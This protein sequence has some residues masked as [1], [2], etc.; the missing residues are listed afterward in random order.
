MFS[1]QDV[2]SSL[3]SIDSFQDEQYVHSFQVEEM[4]ESEIKEEKNIAN[5]IQKISNKIN[6]FTTSFS[7]NE[8]GLIETMKKMSVLRD[9]INDILL[10]EDWLNLIDEIDCKKK[11]LEVNLETWEQNLIATKDWMKILLNNFTEKEFIDHS[12]LMFEDL[13]VLRFDLDL[14]NKVDR[15]DGLDNKANSFFYQTINLGDFVVVNKSQKDKER[16]TGSRLFKE[17]FSPLLD[18]VDEKIKYIE[19][20]GRVKNLINHCFLMIE[21]I[22]LSR[23]GCLNS[24]NRF[25]VNLTIDQKNKFKGQISRAQQRHAEVIQAAI[26]EMHEYLIKTLANAINFQELPYLVFQTLLIASRNRLGELKLAGGNAEQIDL[27]LESIEDL[28]KKLEDCKDFFRESRQIRAQFQKLNEEAAIEKKNMSIAQLNARKFTGEQIYR[29]P[30]KLMHQ[31]ASAHD[32]KKLGCVDLTT[33]EMRFFI[34]KRKVA[35]KNSYRMEI[36]CLLDPRSSSLAAVA[37]MQGDRPTQEDAHIFSLLDFMVGNK[38]YQI[39]LYGIFDGHGG[40]D[41]ASYLAENLPRVLQLN[42]QRALAQPCTPIEELAAIFNTLKTLYEELTQEY[43]KTS[44]LGGSTACI[45]LIYKKMLIAANLGDSRAFINVN[46]S[47]IAL[48]EDAAIGDKKRNRSV[49]KR[50]GFIVE[51][52]NT[53]RITDD[54]GHPTLN[55]THSACEKKVLSANT[56]PKIVTFPLHLLPPGR[57]QLVIACDG[58]FDAIS[59]ISAAKTLHDDMLEGYSIEQAAKNM[60]RRAYSKGSPDNISALIVDLAIR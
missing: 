13:E 56:R 58:V 36:E 42:L 35:K 26:I 45:V 50:G 5:E 25:E 40:R 48:S 44:Y 41:G 47:P 11:C 49:R 21:N 37:H 54:E 24:I 15:K 51:C 53:L 9:L 39:P 16:Q 32:D 30:R 2:N 34:N 4:N 7:I 18:V 23:E 28:D 55:M 33:E 20:Y 38:N 12:L 14:K 1:A 17:L 60:V 46:G 52:R 27:S 29:I 57:R 3:H 59:T 6:E 8:I 22:N 19:E 43:R 31:L 10:F